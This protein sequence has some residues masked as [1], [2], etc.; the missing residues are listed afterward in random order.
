MGASQG[1]LLIDR[2]RRQP[3]ESVMTALRSESH[4]LS[5]SFRPTSFKDSLHYQSTQPVRSPECFCLQIKSHVAVR[6]V[7]VFLLP[8]LKHTAGSYPEKVGGEIRCGFNPSQDQ[9]TGYICKQIELTNNQTAHAHFTESCPTRFSSSEAAKNNNWR[10][11][12]PL[13]CSTCCLTN[14]FY[15]AQAGNSGEQ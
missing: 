15:L 13:F 9:R 11:F 14:Y 7:C 1:P 3:G 2:P 8:T 12:K 4:S 6:R 10:R 5:L